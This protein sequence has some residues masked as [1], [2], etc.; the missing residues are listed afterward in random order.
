MV[1]FQ[2]AVNVISL[3]L[4][5]SISV[6]ETSDD[7]VSVSESAC[8]YLI[9]KEET[10]CA[11]VGLIKVTSVHLQIPDCFQNESYVVEHHRLN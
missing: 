7:P 8:P 9:R 5:E 10:A 11:K 1:A 4:C 6:K 3:M 2:H